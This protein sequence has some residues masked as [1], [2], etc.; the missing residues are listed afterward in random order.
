MKKI[1]KEARFLSA[2]QAG[3]KITRKQAKQFFSLGNPSAAALR[4]QQSGIALVREYTSIKSRV[5]RHA[6]RVV[7]YSIKA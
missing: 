1:G 4:F 6:V 3:R 7:K 5:S 2:L